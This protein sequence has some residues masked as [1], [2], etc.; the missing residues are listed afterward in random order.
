MSTQAHSLSG[1]KG[2]RFFSVSIET[3]EGM[4]LPR[5]TQLAGCQAHFW[6][7]DLLTH[8]K[9]ILHCIYR[10]RQELEGSQMRSKQLVPAML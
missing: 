3:Q 9:G 2:G 10:D 8:T 1:A 7:P 6:N 5:V 4:W